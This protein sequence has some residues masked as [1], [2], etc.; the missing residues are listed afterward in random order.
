MGKY[1]DEQGQ[2]QCKQVQNVTCG[3]Y[4]TFIAPNTTHDSSCIEIPMNTQGSIQISAAVLTPTPPLTNDDQP[5]TSTKS[6]SNKW[7]VVGGVAA[8]V[9]GVAVAAF[10]AWKH[11]KG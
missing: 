8:G 10:A 2:S 6:G 3:D 7:P 11:I 5:S 4:E 1:Q 9:V